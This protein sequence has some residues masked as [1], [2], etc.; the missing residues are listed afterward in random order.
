MK[1]AVTSDI[2]KSRKFSNTERKEVNDAIRRGFEECCELISDADADK[3]SFRVVQGDEFQFLINNPEYA[4]QFVVFFRLILAQSAHKPDFR[5]GIGIGDII[6]YEKNIYEMDGSAFHNSRDALGLFGIT[7]QQ[8]RKTIIKTGERDIDEQFNLI[9]L[10]NDYIE[11][12]WTDK[13]REAIFLYKKHGSLEKAA[14]EIDITYQALQQRI[15]GSGWKQM[16]SGFERY[17]A[18]VFIRLKP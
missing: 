14:A 2:I 10:Y 11:D 15:Q 18:L 6:N 17:S 3:L 1:A 4:C 12:R 8:E 9:T 7:G 5:A 13:Q 16:S